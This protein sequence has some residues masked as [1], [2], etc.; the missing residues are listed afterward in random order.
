[1]T[2]RAAVWGSVLMLVALTGS[3]C[4]DDDG[5]SE[6]A[7]TT[8]STEA[9][10]PSTS[11]PGEEGPSTPV[12]LSDIRLKLTKVAE[13]DQPVGMALRAGDDGLY[14][15]E[16]GGRLRVLRGGAVADGSI[17]DISDQVTTGGE[18]GLLGVAFSPDGNLL[19]ASFTDRE[20]DSRL[21]EFR[22]V[23]GK[24]DPGSRREVMTQDQPYANHN[25]GQITF[26][27]DGFLYYFLG[28]GGAGGDP[29][30]NG[31]KLSTR[32]GKILRINPAA[33]GSAAYTVPPDNPF[34]ARDGALP[35]IYAYGLR[36]PWRNS[37]DRAT[38]DLWIGDVGQN[39]WEEIDWT[40]AG[41]TAGVNY[42]WN[43]FEGT[44][45]FNPAAQAPGHRPPVHEYPNPDQGCSVT[46]GYVYR[47]LTIPTLQGV[48]VFGDFCE[49]Q[50]LGL[51]LEGGKATDVAPLDLKVDSLS[52]FGEDPAGNLYAFSL[53][54]GMFRIDAA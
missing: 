36:N 27:P 6:A 32:L 3:A 40:P 12:A 45:P 4:G 26:G 17:L 37:F 44:K 16:K 34:V 48:Y 33:S 9:S 1:M 47:G 5:G 25:G 13:F 39:A 19:Y 43:A 11:Q 54:G 15:I 28:D 20:G 18:Q 7:G 23:D 2:K 24:A 51:R 41:Q 14:V 38:G 42:G 52:S 21:W 50:L 10:P 29:H 31:Q 35:E 22:F 49:G 30:G 46:G 53:A 8:T